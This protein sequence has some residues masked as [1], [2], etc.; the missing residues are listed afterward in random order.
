M[1]YRYFSQLYHKVRSS[2]IKD[3][4]FR[5]TYRELNLKSVQVTICSLPRDHKTRIQP[6]AP[7]AS[8]LVSAHAGADQSQKVGFPWGQFTIR[9]SQHRKGPSHPTGKRSRTTRGMFQQVGHVG[10]GS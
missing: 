5:P 4:F 1:T 8:L 9:E 6:T 7:R 10:V 3:N 2:Y